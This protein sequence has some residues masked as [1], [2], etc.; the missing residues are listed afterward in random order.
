MKTIGKDL[1]HSSAHL[2]T[3]SIDPVFKRLVHWL[4]QITGAPALLSLSTTP[5]PVLNY[6]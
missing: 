1:M 2:Q 4:Y 3:W 6:R 5:N